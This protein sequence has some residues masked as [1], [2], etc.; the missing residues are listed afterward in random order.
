MRTVTTAALIA[1]T[2]HAIARTLLGA[3]ACILASVRPPRRHQ[4][5]R[6]WL[7]RIVLEYQPLQPLT[8]T[9]A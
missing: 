1:V 3:T 8:A 7:L 6:Q 2:T 5:P 4:S 9:L